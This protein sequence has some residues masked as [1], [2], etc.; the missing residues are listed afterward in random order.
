MKT[1]QTAP[2][3][4]KL[5]YTVLN[6]LNKHPSSKD[7]LEGIAEWWVLRESIDQTVDELNRALEYL[8]S[9]N[10]IQVN[11]H[12][13][14]HK[15]YQINAK[16][17]EEIRKEYFKLRIKGHTNNQCRK[18]LYAK[19]NFEVNIRTLRRWTKKLNEGGWNLKDKS[20]KPKTIHK[21]ITLET[22]EKIISIKNK[23]G[24]GEKKIETI[25]DIG[26]PAARRLGP[27]GQGPVR[28]LTERV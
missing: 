25:V 16:K 21:K 10:L 19:Y 9:E 27:G 24:W 26:L 7:T 8:R 14:H 13:N 11:S 20:T 2:E 23:T 5:A 15:Y 28:P 18:I 12:Q 3:D 1:S 22:E 4:L 17:K 6:Y